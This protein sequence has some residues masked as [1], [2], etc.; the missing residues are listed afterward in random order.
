MK[1]P[2][3]EL[4][5]Q[6]VFDN[7]NFDTGT[8]RLTAESQPTVTNLITIMKCF[9]N[10]QYRLEG[11]TDNTGDAAANKTLSVDRANAIRDLL[12]QGGIDSSRLSTEGYG[13]D[14]PIASNDTEEG[15][16]KNRRTEL[17]VLKK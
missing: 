6:I 3:S 9:P 4:P 5:K 2:D 17:I 14:K 10:S 12:V 8:T 7:L 13:A 15:R 11:H 1:G 16:A